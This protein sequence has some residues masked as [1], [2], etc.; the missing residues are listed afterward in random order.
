MLERCGF[1]ERWQGWIH[2]C[3]S[4]VHILVLINGTPAGFF[5][6]SQG[7]RQGDSLSPLLF[8]LVE[9][10]SRMMNATV[11][12]DL[13]SGFFVGS[14]VMVVSH[15]LFADDTLIFCKPNV[16]Q[17][18][19]LRYLLLCFEVVSG[20]KINLS[21]SII[22]PIGEV[23]DVEGLARILGCGVDSVPFT[24]LGF[25]FGCSL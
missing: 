19:N 1:G 2:H 12:R 8:V 20:L 25:T 3:V 17:L 24:Y 22:A 6:S 18:C 5:S 15:L 9:A 13:M 21:K 10:F 7:V 16:E 23:E 11:E 14:K 4:T